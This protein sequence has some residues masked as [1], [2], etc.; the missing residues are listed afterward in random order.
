[1]ELGEAKIAEEDNGT[2]EVMDRVLGRLRK[3]NAS[4]FELEPMF[5]SAAGE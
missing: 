3:N 5:L 4:A 1:M 2:D